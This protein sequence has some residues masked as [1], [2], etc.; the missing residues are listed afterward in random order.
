MS[1]SNISGLFSAYPYVN[2]MRKTAA[3]QAGFTEQLTNTAETAGTRKD[4]Y[5]DYLRSKFG[6]VS[7]QSVGKDQASL[8][9]A[10]GRMGGHDVVIAPNILEDMANDPKK[11]A[12]YEKKISDYFD[13]I[14]R[15][16]AQFAAQRLVHE[17]GG[18][19]VHAD[20]S[21][22]YIGGCSD[23]PERFAQ[24]RAEQ[25]EKW[26]RR[27]RNMEIS[28]EAAEK[29]RVLTELQNKNQVLAKII[30][31]RMF[32]AGT[33]FYIT[34]LSQAVDPAVMVYQSTMSPMWGSI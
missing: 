28:Q 26:A 18:V 5:L 31:S 3:G 8:Q 22:T 23:P 17:P 11:A 25:E 10:G 20:G 27:K 6:N 34:N 14:P 13:A 33:N 16:N 15:L 21:V 30:Q 29:R 1:I 2:Q 4:R 7:T 19:V 32:D 9:K 24:A 12:Y